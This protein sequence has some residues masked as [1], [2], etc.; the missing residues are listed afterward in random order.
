MTGEN[1]RAVIGDN[2]PPKDGFALVAAEINDLY[3]E[4]K[5]WLDGEP[6]TT[7]GQA[8][9]VEKLLKLTKDTEKRT[10]AYR[11]ELVKP[12]DEQKAA[13]QAR[14]NPLI[15]KR[16]ADGTCGTT[17]RIIELGNQY[18]TPWKQ[19]LLAEKQAEEKRLREVAEKA[20]AE[21]QKAAQAT[22]LE[23][24]EKAERLIQE[25]KKASVAAN[26]VSKTPKGTRTVWNLELSDPVE[27]MRHM[28]K[29]RRADLEEYITQL[30]KQEVN[31]GVRKI[32]GF[33]IK[34]EEV[35]R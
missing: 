12:L 4:A 10:E 31:R 34:S 19:K 2:N 26:K 22:A 27:A 32:P 11:K 29:V 30:A 7:Q 24:R 21:A 5:G 8:D 3:E 16:K 14:F 15:G 23:D 20:A 35:S 1:K 33:K 9:A 18:L 25:A 28:W 13:I 17:V 6:I